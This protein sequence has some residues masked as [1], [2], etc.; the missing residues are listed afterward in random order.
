[1][2]MAEKLNES[3]SENHLYMVIKSF[4]MV[5]ELGDVI[6]LRRYDVVMTIQTKVYTN[7]T[8]YYMYKA[9]SANHDFVIMSNDGEFNN[10]I[11]INFMDMEA[12]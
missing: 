11:R 10:L 2:E 3:F 7:E 8:K 1:M 12:T 5:N 6:A 4:T 9:N